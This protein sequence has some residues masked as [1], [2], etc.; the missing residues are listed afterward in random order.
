MEEGAEPG[1]RPR[2]PVGEVADG[3][4]AEGE[5]TELDVSSC[6]LVKEPLMEGGRGEER[7][8]RRKEE[9]KKD[10]QL[11]FSKREVSHISKAKP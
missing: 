10:H 5:V 11:L 1:T 4:A 9:E 3:E 7:R 6:L 8:E 2:R